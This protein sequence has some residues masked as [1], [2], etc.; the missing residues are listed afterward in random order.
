LIVGG[1]VIEVRKFAR[2]IEAESRGGEHSAK[3]RTDR[4][5]DDWWLRI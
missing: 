4:R 2:Q 3:N 5:W 1:D